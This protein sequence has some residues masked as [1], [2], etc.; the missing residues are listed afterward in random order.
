MLNNI[1]VTQ[2]SFYLSFQNDNRCNSKHR[3]GILLLLYIEYGNFRERP[4]RSNYVISVFFVKSVL[5][6]QYFARARSKFTK[7]F[8][9]LH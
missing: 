2:S 9:F 7:T 3:I 8:D 1:L 4:N 5:I 6:G